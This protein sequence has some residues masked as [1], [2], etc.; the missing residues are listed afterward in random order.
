MIVS[1]RSSVTSSPASTLAFIA[2]PSEDSTPTILMSGL[3]CLRAVETPEMSPP[4]PIG[5]TTTS[6]SGQ[7]S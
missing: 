6:T 7:S 3:S 4:P 5:T 1:Q 2:A